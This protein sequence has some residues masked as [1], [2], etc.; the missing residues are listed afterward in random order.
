[1]SIYLAGCEITSL[2]FFPAKREHSYLFGQVCVCVCLL[3][4]FGARCNIGRP[5]PRWE[6]GATLAREVSKARNV[7]IK[8]GNAMTI[9]TRIHT[10]LLQLS[11]AVQQTFLAHDA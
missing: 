10:V 1:M 7:S 9:G 3:C 5:Q 11:R 2:F 6:D 4:L 8:G